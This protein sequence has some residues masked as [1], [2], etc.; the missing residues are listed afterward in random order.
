MNRKN[1]NAAVTDL[2][3]SYRL[4]A[5]AAAAL[6]LGE[7]A[8]L[9]GEREKAIEQFLLAFVLPDLKGLSVDRA[10]VRRKLG[11]LWK[12]VHGNE[13]GLGERLLQ[14]YD[15]AVAD[16]RPAAPAERNA[17]AKEVH[18]FELRRAD[19]SAAVK[20]SEAKGKVLVLSFWATWCL[21][22]RELEPLFEKVERQYAGQADVMFLAVNTDEDETLVKPFV[23]R[24]KV[25]ST[26]V[27]ADGLDQW[28]K[29]AS[30]PTVMVLDRDGKIVYRGQG[31]A[32]DG[33]A[34]A[35]TAAIEKAKQAP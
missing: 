16:S 21:P 5:N 3:K 1:Y 25:K 18:G 27:F 6:R 33:F 26:V 31:F 34:E 2:E 7:I 35:L 19:G 4:Q 9:R 10:E 32:P 24:E 30:I 22:C 13:N 17:G 29:I 20:L 15:K 11:N 12:Q 14:A 23:E 8:E 28:M